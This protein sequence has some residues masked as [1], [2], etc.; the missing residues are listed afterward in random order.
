MTIKYGGSIDDAALEADIAQRMAEYNART[1]TPVDMEGFATKEA[2]YALEQMRGASKASVSAKLAQVDDAAAIAEIAVLVD[3]KLA[4]KP[5]PV[6]EPVEGV[7]V[8]AKP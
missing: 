6:V 4:E 5:Q 2:L 8:E 3:A 7:K 1:D